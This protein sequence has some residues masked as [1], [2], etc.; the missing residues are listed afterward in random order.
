MILKHSPFRTKLPCVFV[1]RAFGLI[2]FYALLAQAQRPTFLARTDYPDQGALAMVLADFN[3]DGILDIGYIVVGGNPVILFGNGDG[4]FR[5]G[6]PNSG[7]SDG[8]CTSRNGGESTCTSIAVGD[9][10]G[11]GKLDLVLGNNPTS[12]QVAYGNGDGTFQPG[13]LIGIGAV[14]NALA[15]ADVN[16]D[17]LPDIIVS[18]GDFGEGPPGVCRRH[19]RMSY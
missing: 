18:S 5:P 2:G 4:T 19:V 3:G 16:G 13:P 17:G 10:N 7:F 11:D 14:P 6:P 15:V 8:L 12:I 9:L 1:V